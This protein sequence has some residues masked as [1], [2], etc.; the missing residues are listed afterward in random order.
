MGLESTPILYG[1]DSSIDCS[2]LNYT[3]IQIKFSNFASLVDFLQY[4]TGN[5]K[6]VSV[7]DEIV[8]EVSEEDFVKAKEEYEADRYVP[9]DEA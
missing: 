4:F 5:M 8:F 3:M 2:F 1:V 9:Y 7:G 6:P